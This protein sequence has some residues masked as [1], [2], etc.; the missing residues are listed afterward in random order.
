VA[1]SG[2]LSSL[3]VPDTGAVPAFRVSAPRSAAEIARHSS[4]GDAIVRA[5]VPGRPHR[6]IAG[7]AP[8]ERTHGTSDL[9]DAVDHLYC[10]S[11]RRLTRP[12]L[13]PKHSSPRAIEFACCICARHGDDRRSGTHG[14]Q[15][16]QTRWMIG[17]ANPLLCCWSRSQQEREPFLV[18]CTH[19]ESRSTFAFQ[20]SRFQKT[21]IVPATN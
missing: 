14:R 20:A 9:H 18:E 15:Y 1:A 6:A 8:Q 19:L 16:G 10:A 3:R 4:R 21:S 5:H 13:C 17:H 11:I 2:N 12:R 7:H